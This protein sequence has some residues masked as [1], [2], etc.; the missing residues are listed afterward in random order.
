MKRKKWIVT[1]FV[2]LMAALLVIWS[3]PSYKVNKILFAIEASVSVLLLIFTA[4]VGNR[5]RLY[6]RLVLMRAGKVLTAQNVEALNTL[7]MP[8]VVTGSSG[9]ILWCNEKFTANVAGG[10]SPVGQ[11]ISPYIYPRTMRQ[12]FADEGVSVNFTDKEYT[13]YGVKIGDAGVFYFVDDTYFKQIEREY[14]EK[15][16]V[17]ALISFDNK[18]EILRDASGGEESRITAE[19]ESVLRDWAQNVMGGFIRSLSGGRYMLISDETHMEEA[20]KRRFRILDNVREVKGIGNMS[21]TISI[22]IGMGASGAVQSEEWARRALEMALGRGGD[23]V[24]VMKK[25]DAYEFYGG[26]SKGIEKRDK[27]R[28]RVIAATFAEHVTASDRVLV[29]GHRNSDLDAVGSA[30]GIWAAVTRGLDK[31]CHIVINRNQTLA[32]PLIDL[33]ENS[34]DN[35]GM[36][37]SPQEAIGELTPKTL[38][39]V[40]DTHSD[41]FVES[42]ELLSK[43]R[44]IVVIDH[45][46]MMVSHIKNSVIFYHEPFASSASEMVAELIQYIENVRLNTYEAQALLSGIMLDTKNFIMKTG[47]RTFEAA[48]YLRRRGADT[49]EVKKLFANSLSANKEKSLLVGNADIYR[50]CAI[51]YTEVLD[52]ETRLAAAQA[53]DELL[54]LQGVKASF[55]LFRIGNE[56]NISGRSLG[57]VNVQ[58]ILEAFGGGGHLTMAGAQIKDVTIEEARLQL[59]EV[60]DEK[61]EESTVR[62]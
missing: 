8:V 30:V 18:E 47:V 45:H 16:T 53:A 33:L 22:G 11:D 54:S 2:Y 35:A 36:F 60:I 27:V 13:V 34:S 50:D 1:P 3:I 23:Q 5:Q 7:S 42:T 59:I 56:V 12:I 61:L 39:V 49:V 57:E 26:L 29:M 37:I 15:K 31:P 25:G 20:R 51:A 28:T 44:K 55:V 62:I 48:A 6:T 41:S 38:L 14:R 43:S 32:T 9:D 52:S 46:R 24:A 21:C 19:V 4:L 40:V 58:L 17:V 10:N